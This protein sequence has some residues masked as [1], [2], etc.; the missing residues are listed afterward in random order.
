MNLKE[1]ISIKH[2]SYEEVIN[3]F[4]VKNGQPKFNYSDNRGIK[5]GY[6]RHHIREDQESNLS[7]PE[8][9]KLFPHLQTPDQL[10]YLK[11]EEHLF[12]H[13]LISSEVILKDTASE[14]CEDLSKG[15]ISLILN[16]HYSKMNKHLLA[17]MFADYFNKIST[18]ALYEAD[19]STEALEVATKIF[20]ITDYLKLEIEKYLAKN[21]CFSHNKLAYLDVE[22]NL[23]SHPSVIVEICTGGGKTCLGLEYMIQHKQEGKK[24]L[25]VVPKNNIK[26]GWESKEDYNG[27]LYDVIS[28]QTLVKEP[29]YKKYLESGCY[30]GIIIDEVHHMHEAAKKWNI[31]IKYAKEKGFKILGLTATPANS[32]RSS[33]EPIFE[34]R[35]VVGLDI[36]TAIKEGKMWPFNYISSIYRL[37]NEAISGI[38]DAEYNILCGPID[39]FLKEHSVPSI[40]LET[41]AQL[42]R[43]QRK[44]IIYVSDTRNIPISKKDDKLAVFNECISLVKGAYPNAEFVIISSHQTAELN[45]QN[46]QK[47]I[48]EKEKDIFLVSYGMVNEG[49]HY[50]GV[51]TLIMFRA[52]KSDI[53]FVQQLGRI[54][55][56]RK[57]GDED[58]QL[59]VFDF[60]NYIFSAMTQEGT[61]DKIQSESSLKNKKDKILN[62]MKYN[63]GMD[64]ICRCEHQNILNLLDELRSAK[65]N[66]RKNTLFTEAMQELNMNFDDLSLF[67]EDDLEEWTNMKIDAE[68]TIKIKAGPSV[69]SDSIIN[70]SN[71]NDLGQVKAFEDKDSKEGKS[72]ITKGDKTTMSKPQL[73]VY[74]I[75][76]ISKWAFFV[77]AIDEDLN[78]IYDDKLEQFCKFYKIKKAGYERILASRY[79]VYLKGMLKLLKNSLL[80]V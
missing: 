23:L 30:W 59:V 80:S 31:P 54:M 18:Q 7:S 38:S 60:T 58:P 39:V 32:Q 78:I 15:G 73:L 69:I 20:G 5:K 34:G 53:L 67:F 9:Q 74:L 68:E 48:N 71:K 64:V 52:T 26:D 45:V 27:K 12:V 35:I 79:S 28:I 44:G 77:S 25:V 6:E 70:N 61:S 16:K 40:I 65:D 29:T 56:L 33:D 72:V 76:L 36:V 13:L 66:T 37:N 11:P 19:N 22:S 43:K 62:P 46:K 51:N 10:V 3:Y 75:T 42:D 14:K 8:K 17:K 21:L 24:F 1:Y 55:R 50:E 49:S 47:F 63:E 4:I 41:E 2:K 57:D